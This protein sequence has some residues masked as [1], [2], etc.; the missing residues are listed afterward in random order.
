[1]SPGA[2]AESIR[3][4][5][6]QLRHGRPTPL[7]TSDYCFKRAEKITFCGLFEVR[8]DIGMDCALIELCRSFVDQDKAIVIFNTWKNLFQDI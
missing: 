2:A 5:R 8:Y 6:R 7:P 3:E 4:I 1:M